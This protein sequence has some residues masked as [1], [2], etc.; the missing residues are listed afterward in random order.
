MASANQFGCLHPGFS[1]C[2]RD[3]NIHLP[4]MEHDLMNIKRLAC[5]SHSN[6]SPSRFS[7]YVNKAVTLL[8][9]VAGLRSAVLLRVRILVVYQQSGL[10]K[11]SSSLLYCVILIIRVQV[12]IVV[13]VSNVYEYQK[14]VCVYYSSTFIWLVCHF[15]VQWNCSL[16]WYS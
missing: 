9:V 6:Q 2:S 5:R 4:F 7:P 13:Q 8:L 14:N 10:A 11:P 1:C 3:N 16:G 12:S 15:L